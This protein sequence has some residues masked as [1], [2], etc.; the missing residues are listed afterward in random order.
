MLALNLL[1]LNP[2]S[3]YI[4]EAHLSRYLSRRDQYRLQNGKTPYLA[5]TDISMAMRSVPVPTTLAQRRFTM[6]V[7]YDKLVH[8]RNKRKQTKRQ[9][10]GICSTCKKLEAQAHILLEC[11]LSA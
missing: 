2:I 3:K 1:T 4:N 9:E 6:H 8:G 11:S 10:D 5:D 7:I